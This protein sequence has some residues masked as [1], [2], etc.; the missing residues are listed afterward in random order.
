MRFFSGPVV[1]PAGQ[2]AILDGSGS[3]CA[4][5]DDV[6]G[7]ATRGGLVAGRMEAFLVSDLHQPRWHLT[8]KSSGDADIEDP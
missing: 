1:E 5:G 7:L 3:A 6:V 8:K 4:E 2:A